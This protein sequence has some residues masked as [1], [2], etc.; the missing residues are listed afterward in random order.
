MKGLLPK[1]GMCAD[2]AQSLA[3]DGGAIAGTESSTWD[4]QEAMELVDGSVRWGARM[5]QSVDRENRNCLKI[6]TSNVPTTCSWGILLWPDFI[7]LLN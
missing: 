2:R 5:C 7:H 4:E 3:L 1:F 6:H